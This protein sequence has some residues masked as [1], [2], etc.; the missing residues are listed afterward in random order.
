MSVVVLKQVID[1]LAVCSSPFGKVEASSALKSPS[2]SSLTVSAKKNKKTRYSWFNHT[3]Q[4]VHHKVRWS[5]LHLSRNCNVELIPS[6]EHEMIGWNGIGQKVT[7]P[8]QNKS[9]KDP[10]SW[11]D[12]SEKMISNT[13]W[14]PLLP[15]ISLHWSPTCV[16]TPPLALA[17][18]V[19]VNNWIYIKIRQSCRV[20]FKSSR[21]RCLSFPNVCVFVAVCECM[22]CATMAW[23]L[24]A[25]C[26]SCEA[27]DS[28][29]LINY[30]LP[31]RPTQ[32]LL[33]IEA[34][35]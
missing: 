18:P 2:I 35:R 9:M 17:L 29:R 21:S 13:T 25:R 32:M 20:F 27:T 1:A 31:R 23:R 33:L 5:A 10:G 26:S 24:A 30:L 15:F 7:V 19:M 14:S 4:F 3:T 16:W 8:L 22:Q 28:S 12:G 34:Q 11:E 6:T